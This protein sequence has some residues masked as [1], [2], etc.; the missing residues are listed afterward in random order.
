[1]ELPAG[2]VTE[3][4]PRDRAVA[5]VL[6]DVTQALRQSKISNEITESEEQIVN[7]LVTR[8]LGPPTVDARSLT[9]RQFE[10]IRSRGRAAD[11]I[12]AEFPD[13]AS[14]PDKSLGDQL[15]VVDEERV[16]RVYGLLARL[17]EG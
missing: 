5:R 12:I 1:V 8:A 9:F 14:W 16:T 3:P 15:K 17:V 2:S 7:E 11:A 6:L 4:D 10:T 13:W